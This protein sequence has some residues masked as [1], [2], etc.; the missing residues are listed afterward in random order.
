ML[1][2]SLVTLAI[3]LIAVYIG[4]KVKNEIVQP[5]VALTVLVSLF[6]SF[7]FTPWPIVLLIIVAILVINQLIK[8][9]MQADSW[10]Q[11]CREVTCPF[12]VAFALTHRCAAYPTTSP[13]WR[14][15]E[16]KMLKI[17]EQN[18]CCG[19]RKNR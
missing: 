12:P 6:S 16:R 14:L 3:A 10:R 5:V 7:V 1:V 17:C 11:E 13:L 4:S 8:P 19:S 15:G 9:L 18:G 2:L